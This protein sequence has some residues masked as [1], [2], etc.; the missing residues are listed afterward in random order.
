MSMRSP[1]TTISEPGS[2]GGGSGFGILPPPPQASSAKLEMTE[3]EDADQG[4]A[5]AALHFADALAAVTLTNQ[6][7][8]SSSRRFSSSRTQGVVSVTATVTR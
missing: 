8:R 1:Q 4:G 2:N 6:V 5:R 3:D 7:L